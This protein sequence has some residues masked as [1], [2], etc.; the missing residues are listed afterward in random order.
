MKPGDLLKTAR[1]IA[2]AG[3]RGAPR[4][5]NLRRAVSIGAFVTLRRVFGARSRF[6]FDALEKSTLA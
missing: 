3:D 5:S 2:E 4:R 6:S 1:S